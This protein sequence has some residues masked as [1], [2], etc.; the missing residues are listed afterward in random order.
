MSTVWSLREG[1]AEPLS[2]HICTAGQLSCRLSPA[3]VSKHPGVAGQMLSNWPGL[4]CACAE[5]EEAGVGGLAPRCWW[6]RARASGASSCCQDGEEP[7]SGPH[8]GDEALGSLEHSPVDPC[9]GAL[10][11]QEAWKALLPSMTAL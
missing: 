6:A 7:L 8:C 5:V 10:Q 11:P 9:G 3:R 4:R 1:G 2:K